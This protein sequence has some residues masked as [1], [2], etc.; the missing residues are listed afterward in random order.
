MSSPGRTTVTRRGLAALAAVVVSAL[1]LT[2]PSPARAEPGPETARGRRHEPAA[3]DT[4]GNLLLRRGR[5]TPLEAPPDA[6]PDP[7]ATTYTNINNRGQVLGGYY[8]AGATRDAQGF[9]P[10]EAHHSVVRDTWGRHTRYT[11]IDVPDADITLAYDLNDRTQVV[12]QYIDRGAVPDAQ[13]RLPAGTVHGFMWHRGQFT[14]VDVPGAALTQPLGINNQGVIVGAYIEAVPSSDPYAYYDTGRLRGFMMR[15]GKVTPIDFPGGLGTKVSGI[16]DRGQMVGYYD[17]EDGRRGFTLRN[18]RF[19]KIDLPGSL[20][21]L[22]SGIDNRG[23]IVGGYLDPNGVNGRGFLWENGRFTTIVAP[24]ERT[25]TIAFD[26][27]DRGDIVIPTDGNIYRQPEV[28]CGRPTTPTSASG[29]PD[30]GPEG[31]QMEAW[32]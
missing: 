12:G 4:C 2:S 6:S 30:A 14:T 32:Q 17:T 25:D 16:N 22:P 21:T 13:R 19:T 1:A 15:T 26:L 24:G 8:E 10:I 18:G 5:F 28:A 23:R 11:R 3:A 20:F 9:Y 31:L 29:T 7:R 27:N